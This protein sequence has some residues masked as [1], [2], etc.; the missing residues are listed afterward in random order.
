MSIAVLGLSA[1]HLSHQRSTYL[2]SSHTRTDFLL[3]LTHRSTPRAAS[4]SRSSSTYAPTDDL[5]EGQRWSTWH[6]RR[7]AHARP[8]AAPRLGRD[9][10]GAIDTELGIL[11]TGKEAD[12]FLVERADPHRAR[13]RRRDGR[14]ALPRAEHRTFHRVRVLHRGPLDEAVP[15][16]ARPEAE[17]H[18]R[19][20]RSR[21]ASGR[22]PSG[23]RSCRLLGPRPAR[24]PTRCRSTAPRS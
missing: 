12:V 2:D 4:T 16:R 6:D 21:P 14:Q 10:Q 7:A 13:R 23:A 22:C 5:G 17:E 3:A 20:R 9:L 24:S 15:R 1:D 8:R 11:K 19:A 18:V